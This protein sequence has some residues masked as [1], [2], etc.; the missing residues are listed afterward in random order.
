VWRQFAD[1]DARPASRGRWRAF[2]VAAAVA[3]VVALLLGQRWQR[4]LRELMDAPDPPLWHVLLVPVVAALMFVVL[5]ATGRGLRA[6]YRRLSAL[7]ARWMGPRGARALG[8]IVVVAGAYLLVSGVL[9]DGLVTA[10]DRSFSVRDTSTPEGVEQPDDELRS[11][12]PASTVPWDELG[13]QGRIFVAGGPTQEEITE[14]QGAEALAPI[15]AYAGIAAAEDAERRAQL[16]VDDLERAGG[17][18]R[19]SLLVATTT[20]TGWLDPGS[21]DSFE[22]IARGDS[23]IV[24]M[25]YSYLPSWLSYL[26]DQARAR[27]AGRELFDAVYERWSALPPEQ[28]PRLYVFGESLGSFGGETAFSGEYDLRNRTA[29]ALFVGPPNFNV[30]Y[31]EFTDGRDAGSLEV[32]PVYRDGR[33]VRFTNDVAAG[34]EPTSQPWRGTRVLYLQHPSDP[35][36]WWGGHLVLT[37][38]DW[39]EEQ[40]GR[41]VLDEMVWIPFVTFWQVTAD[42]L[43]S[44]GVP[45]GHGHVYTRE[46]VDA[47]ATL[48]QPD[49]WTTDQAERLREIVAA[50]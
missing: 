5:V 13:R 48:L 6:V 11:G 44:T 50:G 25:Q 22:Y 18:Q 46:G 42:M 47:W 12:S 49:G 28:R 38:P 3:L 23:A 31:R 26:V 20:G 39:L 16:A 35:I 30:L 17:F 32:E 27:E 33:T 19:A 40:R 4:Q 45:D 1:R 7:L 36:V 24:G 37:R 15:R 34:V 14:F 2:L 43:F 10:A 29:G 8:W 21:M 41:D 9:L